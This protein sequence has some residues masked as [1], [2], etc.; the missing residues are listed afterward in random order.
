MYNL[1]MSLECEIDVQLFLFCDAYLDGSGVNGVVMWSS[2]K[3]SC[4]STQLLYNCTN[5]LRPTT[6]SK[7][8]IQELVSTKNPQTHLYT[9]EPTTLQTTKIYRCQNIYLHNMPASPPANTFLQQYP[10]QKNGRVLQ[11][12]QP[13][14]Q[15]NNACYPT[16]SNRSSTSPQLPNAKHRATTTHLTMRNNEATSHCV[17][18]EVIQ[19]L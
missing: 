5:Y 4:C 6:T 18:Q 13:K 8:P 17:I 3:N 15:H 11:S 2:R 16:K 7:Q 9:F 14:Q 12:S 10:R 1:W 19:Q